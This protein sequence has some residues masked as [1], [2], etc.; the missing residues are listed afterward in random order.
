MKQVLTHFCCWFFVRKRDSGILSRLSDD[1]IIRET[2]I[3]VSLKKTLLCH[4]LPNGVMTNVVFRR[5][6]IDSRNFA[7]CITKCFYNYNDY[8]EFITTCFYNYNSYYND[9]TTLRC[10]CNLSESDPSPG[11]AVRWQRLLSSP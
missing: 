5:S 1:Q 3:P 4:R 9:F 2:C 8:N 11:H 10:L 6:A 7:M